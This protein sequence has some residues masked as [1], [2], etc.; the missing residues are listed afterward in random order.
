M[1]CMGTGGNGTEIL[2]GCTGHQSVPV[3]GY[4]NR[5]PGFL[6][7]SDRHSLQKPGGNVLHKPGRIFHQIPFCMISV[8]NSSVFT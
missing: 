1:L 7:Q 4:M 6:L 8:A 2:S 3:R 5:K